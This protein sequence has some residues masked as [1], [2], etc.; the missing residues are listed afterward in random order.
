[1]EPTSTECA[2]SNQGDQSGPHLE[3]A[4]PTLP[5]TRHID[6][7]SS[8][9]DRDEQSI[10]VGNCPVNSLNLFNDLGRV[11]NAT[12]KTNEVKSV[13]D[14]L[15]DAQKYKLIKDHYVPPESYIFPVVY[16]KKCYRRF[17]P[18]WL[19]TH[20]WL[21]Y[22]PSIDGAFCKFCALFAPSDKRHMYGTLVNVPWSKW[23][24]Y[25]DN[26]VSHP[27]KGYHTQSVEACKRLIATMDTP[28]A[29]I[30]YQVISKTVL[31]YVTNIAHSIM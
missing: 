24:S 30:P 14:T 28:S 22:S 17:N 25:T 3:P 1:M 31:V 5:E 27:S 4:S 9:V 10:P 2:P 26:V 8:N 21:V 15:S 13:V 11:I 7:R 6:C 23:G 18:A 29:T 19:D 12:M 16:H 20:P